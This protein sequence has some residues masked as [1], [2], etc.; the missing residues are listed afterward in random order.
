MQKLCMK[1]RT[2]CR[3]D[4]VKPLDI[5]CFVVDMDE[6]QTSAFELGSTGCAAC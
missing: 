4:V 3:Q 1:K 2:P 5:L 6:I